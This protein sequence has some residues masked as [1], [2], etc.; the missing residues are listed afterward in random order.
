MKYVK[1]IGLEIEGAWYQME[2]K[3][4]PV[5]YHRDGSVKNIRPTRNGM[6]FRHI[7]EA[8]STP[9]SS[10]NE[11]ASW[12]T[13]YWPDRKNKTCGFHIHISVE[14]EQYRRLMQRS[15]YDL[16]LSEA[17]KFAQEMH[18]S[19]Q[20]IERLKGDNQYCQKRFTPIEQAMLLK[21]YGRYNSFRYNHLNYCYS[22]H[23]TLENRLP[24][25][26]MPRKKAIATV[27]WFVNLI[28]RFLE[29]DKEKINLKP[30]VFNYTFEEA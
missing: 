5:D 21:K 18:L 28:E 7:G 29:Q 27:E 13:D 19:K 25:A 8:V 9:L 15:F 20:F 16:F 30:L 23:G 11:V 14:P 4:L 12:I 17:E 6:Q 2:R 10:M 24:C 1:K 3:R 22:L 26:I